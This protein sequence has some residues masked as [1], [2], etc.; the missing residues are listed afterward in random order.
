MAASALNPIG[1]SLILASGAGASFGLTFGLLLVPRMV[2]SKAEHP[3]PLA[4]SLPFSW[5][6]IFFAVFVAAVFIGVF[7]PGVRWP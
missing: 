7:G 6:W 1:P 5:S 3:G 2:E 4:Q